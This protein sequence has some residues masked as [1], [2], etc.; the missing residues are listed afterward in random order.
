VASIGLGVAET[1]P[2]G[3]DL[4]LSYLPDRLALFRP[5][6]GGLLESTL[7]DAAI[8]ARFA[9]ATLLG[10]VVGL[11]REY[12]GKAAGMRTFALIALGAAAFTGIAIAR[13]PISGDRVIQ[14]IVA[15]IGFLGAGIIFQREEGVV[16]GLTTAAS[17]W[18]VA[19]IG[20]LV[21]SSAYVSGLAATF[22]ALVILE[23][24]RLPVLRR[25]KRYRHEETLG[26]P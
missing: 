16:E 4:R 5:R 8:A 25:F 18:S 13:F 19:A 22:L 26:E 12:R 2:L 14:G 21:G 17:I 3:D 1:R 15:G 6:E 23:I 20:V 10:F 24:D 7:A 11:E 9:L